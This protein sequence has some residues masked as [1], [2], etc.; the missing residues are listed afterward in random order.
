MMPVLAFHFGASSDIILFNVNFLSSSTPDIPI[1]LLIWMVLLL[2]LEKS[3]RKTAGVYLEDILVVLYAVWA[4]TIKLS[5]F[6][7]VIAC[8]YIF[9]QFIKARKYKQLA[10]LC[11]TCFLFVIPWLTRNVLLS[12]YILFPFSGVDIFNVPWKLPIQHVK[13]FEN[14]VKA[15]ALGADLNHTF[16]TPFSKWFPA[17]FKGLVF[18]KQLMLGS[19]FVF[20]GVFVIIGFIRLFKNP[21]TFFRSYQREAV[22]TIT[23][24][25]AIYFWLNKGPDFRFGYGFLSVYCVFFIVVVA[26]YCFEHNF[27]YIFFPVAFYSAAIAFVY[28][29]NAWSLGHYFFKAPIS[30]RMPV[31]TKTI[32]I[33]NGIQLHLVTHDDTWNAPLPAASAYEYAVLHTALLGNKINEGFKSTN[34]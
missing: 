26:R 21:T 23:S 25:V 9:W 2:L 19:A 8:I 16:D 33:G 1:C 14:A 12:G 11:V 3:N 18:I 13:W 15:S 4:L 20:S 24:I 5:A 22:F 28:Y 29:K 6:P 31:E 30:Y 10:Y 7:V 17:W 34:Q 27:H 32:N